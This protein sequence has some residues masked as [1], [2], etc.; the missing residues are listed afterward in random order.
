MTNATR[1][2][3]A[4]EEDL[5]SGGDGRG[6]GRRPGPVRA[7]RAQLRLVA[8]R[9]FEIVAA[10]LV[11]AASVAVLASDV[12]ARA[13]ITLSQASAA[14]WSIG[15]LIALFWSFGVTWREEG[16]SDRA[17][18]WTLPVDRSRHQLLRTAAGWVTLVGV[19]GV[20]LL[21]GW[22]GGALVQGGM[23]VG[24]PQVL[25]A[26]LPAATVLYLVGGLFSLTTDR[27][28]VWLFVTYVTIGGARALG[29]LAG[30]PWLE[31]VVE[32]VILAGPL[33]LTAATVAPGGV[34]GELGG[35]G[36]AGAPW[37]AV[38][39]W[40]AVTVAL[41]VLASRLHLERDGRG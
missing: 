35:S 40:L 33:S 31:R 25:A 22:I 5:S 12:F 30:W 36:A 3:R 21:A 32:E 34:A 37:L 23:S 8:R 19:L 4:G 38:A 24:R 39:L 15:V 14:F 28:L 10:T 2:T 20:G 6:G 16:P 27:P 29:A 9:R 11:V 26:V 41:T 18:H 13:P 17:Y 1:P 7:F